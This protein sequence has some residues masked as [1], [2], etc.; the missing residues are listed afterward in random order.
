MA[1]THEGRRR[2]ETSWFKEAVRAGREIEASSQRMVRRSRRRAVTGAGL[3]VMVGLGAFAAWTTTSTTAASGTV[4]SWD[5]T[6]AAQSHLSEAP[7]PP[8]GEWMTK[9]GGIDRP[10]ASPAT[11]GGPEIDAGFWLDGGPRP[12]R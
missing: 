7:L 6:M 9:D 10:D 2:A 3:V 1:T 12:V 11:D 4:F 5:T 8:A